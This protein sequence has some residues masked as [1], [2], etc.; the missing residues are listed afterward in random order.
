MSA[1]MVLSAIGFIVILTLP[2]VPG[3]VELLNPRDDEPLTIDQ[4]YARDPRFFGRSFR[5]KL[6]PFLDRAHRTLPYRED[7]VLRR[8]ETLEVF[9]DLK[10]EGGSTVSSIVATVGPLAVGAGSRLGEVYAGGPATVEEGTTVR[11]LASDGDVTLGDDCN[12]L[13]WVDAEGDVSC[14]QGCDLGHSVSAAGLVRL[15][16][17]TTFRRL[18]GLPVA[19][20]GAA[21]GLSHV[22]T[23]DDVVI[24]GQNGLS[25]PPDSRLERDLVVRGELRIGAGS[26]VHGN[27]KAHGRVT[28]EDGAKVDGNLIARANVVLGEGVAINGSVF[29]EGDIEVGSGTHIGDRASFKSLYSLSQIVLG[30]DVRI[31]GWVVAERGGRVR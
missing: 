4:T 8:P 1:L 22:K 14:G 5:S 16:T 17:A 31:F 2:F 19:T 29:A 6:R 30:S 25:F 18:W 7:I 10:I 15:R 20:E 3:L 23:I 24:F 28:I 11:S 21:Y 27:I 26:V 12:I 9:N 13:R